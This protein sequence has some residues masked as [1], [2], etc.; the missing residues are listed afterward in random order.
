MV[1]SSLLFLFRFLPIALLI[2]YLMPRKG[3]NFALLVLSMIFYAWGEVRYL[4]IMVVSILVDYFCGQG[5]KRWGQK[6]ALRRMFLIFSM[7][8]NLGMLF[9]FK[10]TNFFLEN[11]SAITGLALPQ[12]SLTLPLG[13][14]FYTF[15]TMSYTIDVYR[16]KVEAED[17][18][19]DF[20][21]FVVLF[22]QLIAG[23]IVKYSDVAYE[24]K[25][26]QME[27]G[28]MAEGVRLFI[29]GLASKVLIANNVGALWTEIEGLSMTDISTPLAWLG[30]LAFSLQI[31]FDFSGYSLMAIGLGK[32]LGFD[33]PQNFN[34]PYI[35]PSITDFWRRWHMTLSSWFREYLYI[36][37]G[38]NREGQWKT[39]RNMLIVWAATG[40]WHG[41]SWNFVLWGLFFFVMLVLEKAWL[42]PHMARHQG[43]SRV[44]VLFLLLCS[45][46]L[47]AITDLGRLG[48]YF[49]RMF[50]P[51][52]GG[53]WLYY[54]RNYGVSLVLG[55]VLSV[56][57]LKKFYDKWLCR[58]RWIE[59]VL[60]GGLLTLSVAYLVDAT[61][62]PFL[63]FR[64]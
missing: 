19:I 32:L 46:M 63:Y 8:L 20:G 41:A 58:H 53:N 50:V 15:Q 40:F 42:A 24:L 7:V 30:A 26:R 62:N 51:Q 39:Y 52:G 12:L 21:A 1:F 25:H 48:E 11:I 13:I 6:P 61:Y 23:P 35:S 17:N 9:F 59:T 29:M 27:T 33:F 55:C 47:F 3:K 28:R 45:W 16:G 54:L 5:I 60:L 43:I 36:P 14:S 10:Y 56:P 37:L 44:W 64:F 18:I 57:V 2:Y 22:P 31:Y 38:G 49:T 34:Y 4:P